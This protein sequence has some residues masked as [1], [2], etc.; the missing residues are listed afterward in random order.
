MA[1]LIATY[2]EGHFSVFTEDRSGM[3]QRALIDIGDKTP[4]PKEM[5]EL[6][7]TLADHWGWENR[8][9][10]SPMSKP[11]KAIEPT[12]R[13]TREK[14]ISYAERERL[15]L[16][17]LAKHPKSDARQIV[18]GCGYEPTDKRTARWAIGFVAMRKAQL[19]VGEKVSYRSSPN[20]APVNKYLY[21][22][23]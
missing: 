14:E 15:T 2:A 22:L 13:R 18:K 5:A 7:G 3:R 8:I 16:Q 11:V 19:I 9:E 10:R 20:Q 23:P 4:T 21:S 12:E 1:R 6:A 17:F